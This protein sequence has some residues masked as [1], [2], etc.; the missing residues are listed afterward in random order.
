[1][2]IHRLLIFALILCISALAG[3]AYLQY[4]EGLTPCLLCLLQRWALIGL[5]LCIVVALLH[6]PSV[7]GYS[8]YGAGMLLFSLFGLITAGRQ[9]WLQQLPAEQQPVC[10]P[11]FDYLIDNF[12]VV[13]T[14]RYMFEGDGNCA[15]IDWTFLGQCIAVW[16]LALFGVLMI[17]SVIVMAK[18]I[19]RG[20]SA[21]TP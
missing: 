12:P 6:R 15:A 14:L 18:R 8:V 16:S 13:D 2:T 1:M 9:V 4:V 11:G 5:T 3:A 17:V 10:G 7:W 19:N 20:G 21:T